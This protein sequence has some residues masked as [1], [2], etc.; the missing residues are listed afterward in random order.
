[1][2]KNIKKTIHRRLDMRLRSFLR[3]FLDNKNTN[4][5]NKHIRRYE[6]DCYSS[7]WRIW[8]WVWY[9]S[10]NKSSLFKTMQIGYWTFL[11][12]TCKTMVYMAVLLE[13]ISSKFCMTIEQRLFNIPVS[14]I[15]IHLSVFTSIHRVP[16]GCKINIK[17]FPFDGDGD[18]VKCHWEHFSNTKIDRDGFILFEVITNDF[19]C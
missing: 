12:Y 2:S 18:Y 19:K 15:S 4:Y 16:M 10:T 8:I 3:L 7:A 13:N 11:S 17:L 1:M 9:S 6:T 5:N 14:Y